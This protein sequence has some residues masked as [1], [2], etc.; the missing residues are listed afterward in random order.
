MKYSMV[1]DCILDTTVLPFLHTLRIGMKSLEE[2]VM[3]EV[4]VAEVVVEGVV[5]EEVEVEKVVVVFLLC[6]MDKVVVVFLLHV[7]DKDVCVLIV[8]KQQAAEDNSNRARV[9]GNVF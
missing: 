1:R 4:M 6:V 7:M 9:T 5:V 2:V 3:A 8:M